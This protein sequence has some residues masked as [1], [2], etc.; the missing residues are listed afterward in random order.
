MKAQSDRGPTVWVAFRRR[1]PEDV[2]QTKIIGDTEDS[3]KW[4][5]K[6]KG[7]YDRADSQEGGTPRAP[8]SQ[9][10]P[11]HSRSSTP[12]GEVLDPLTRVPM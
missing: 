4:V 9:V 6:G 11:A 12:R 2:R 3:V 1:D 10:T 8:D 5:S 7:M